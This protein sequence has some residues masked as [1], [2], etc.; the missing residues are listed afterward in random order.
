MVTKRPENRPE[1][2]PR[3]VSAREALSKPLKLVSK[4][5][6]QEIAKKLQK[7]GKAKGPNDP[8]LT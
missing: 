7:I 8:D 5:R 3:E 2:G 4:S 6:L 1:N